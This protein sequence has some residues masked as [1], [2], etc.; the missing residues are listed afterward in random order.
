VV[1]AMAFKIFFGLFYI[2]LRYLMPEKSSGVQ[3]SYF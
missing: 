1:F 3:K 2:F